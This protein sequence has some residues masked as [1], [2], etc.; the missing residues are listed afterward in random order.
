MYW[1]HCLNP[2]NL[3]PSC[4]CPRLRLARRTILLDNRTVFGP[5]AP[6]RSP[7]SAGGMLTFAQP[8]ERTFSLKMNT[9]KHT[10]ANLV[11]TL[12]Q[13]HTHPPPSSQHLPTLTPTRRMQTDVRCEDL[14]AF[15]AE[16]FFFCSRLLSPRS[17]VWEEFFSPPLFSCNVYLHCFFVPL[18]LPNDMFV[19]STYGRKGC[20]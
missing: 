9:G 14:C 1:S 5:S 2:N 3:S 20:S 11:C 8:G 12:T 16:V 6:S 15:C 7:T 18:C 17:S 10:H 19:Y 13:T 4:G